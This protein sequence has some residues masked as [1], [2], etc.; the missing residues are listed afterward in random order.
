MSA[1]QTDV[2]FLLEVLDDGRL[3]TLNEILER[4]FRTRGCGLTVHS[5]V[6]ELRKRGHIITNERI[7]GAVRGYASGYRLQG[8]GEPL[9]ASSPHPHQEAR[10][11]SEADGVS[12][13]II[14]GQ[15]SIEEALADA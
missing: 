14:P 10:S 13:D 6:A 1:P 3:H 4:S 7:P 8:S 9:T 5:R 11:P 15:L 12:P 2:Q